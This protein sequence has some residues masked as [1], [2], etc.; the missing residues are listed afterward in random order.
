[1]IDSRAVIDPSARLAEDVSVGPFCVIGA[2]VEIGEGSV[3]DSHVVLKGPTRIGR[4]NR[5]FPFATIGEDT[6]DLKYQGEPTRLEIGDDNVIREGVTI[7]RGTVQDKSVTIIGNHN[8]IMAYAHIG[9]DSVVGD[10]CI[11]V[12][13][14]ALAG[15][16]EVGDWAILSGYTLVHQYCKIGAHA[17][18]GMGTAVGKDIPAYIMVS[19][20]PAAPHNI[21]IEGLKRRGF[22]PEQI[23]ALR[24]AYKVIYRQGNTTDEAIQQ[25]QA[26]AGSEAAL[27][28]LIE[29]LQNSGRGIVR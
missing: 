23:S 27:A 6:P 17:F 7:H 21:N 13:N 24:K 1:M 10:H 9:H 26:M 2:D 4:R 22:T 15:H 5:I 8:L 14:S 3:I 16:V 25:L 19:G 18:T 12:N 20:N 11:M 28:P 29:S